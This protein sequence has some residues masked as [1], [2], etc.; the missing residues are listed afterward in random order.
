MQKLDRS[1]VP[2]ANARPT[3]MDVMEESSELVFRYLQTSP[4]PS[5]VLPKHSEE[6][7]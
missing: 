2:D 6:V 7:F 5:E 1:A 3:G 4:P